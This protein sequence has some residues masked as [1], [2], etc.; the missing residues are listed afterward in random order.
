MEDAHTVCEE[1]YVAT[2]SVDEEGSRV[3]ELPNHSLFAVF[4]GHGGK[5][6]SDYASQNL[7][8]VL[9]RT[10]SFAEYAERIGI[11]ASPLGK[12]P[13]TPAKKK[14]KKN[15]LRPTTRVFS[16]DEKQKLSQ[17]L[18]CALQT[19]FVDLDREI[20]LQ[21]MEKN[22]DINK[23]L[24]KEN[25][26]H[27]SL[28]AVIN[29]PNEEGLAEESQSTTI[30]SSSESNE[31]DKGSAGTTAIV[32]IITPD[33]IVCGNAGDSRAVL[34][35]HANPSEGASSTTNEA[36]PLS[37]DHK[38]NNPLEM[39]RI[40]KAGG[41][42]NF[43]RVDGM[44]AVSR[45]LGDFPFKDTNA[46]LAASGDED[47]IDYS[48]AK[49]RT[50]RDQKVSPIP[51]VLIHNRKDDD[52]SMKD[53]FIIM[54]CDGIWDVVS[55]EECMDLVSAMLDEGESNCGLICEELLDISLKKGSS[56]NMTATV[57]RFPGQQIGQGGG[58]MKRRKNRERLA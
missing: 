2:K 17:L 33:F 45:A 50:A 48:P 16:N 6:A 5:F 26:N 56:D 12:S 47:D 10:S 15:N 27:H 7:V 51:D 21:G 13:K 44:L 22:I 3:I 31:E 54:A 32:I 39:E 25:H 55:N 11:G 53:K 30:N 14:K 18:E 38:P 42:V 40:L 46:I 52:N 24:K 1:I 37:F 19:T 41:L 34:C 28:C 57:I 29:S 43:S 49:I 20:L 23:N 4:D 58:V 35:R 36:I 9:S 8:R